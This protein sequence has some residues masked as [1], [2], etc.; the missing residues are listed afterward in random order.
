MRPLSL[1]LVYVI[2]IGGFLGAS[3]SI[4]NFPIYVFSGLTIWTL[5]L[6]IVGAGTG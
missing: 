2:A 4:K 6:E 1:M 5:F 3:A